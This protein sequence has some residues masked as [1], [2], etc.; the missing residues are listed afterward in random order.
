M[1]AQVASIREGLSFRQIVAFDVLRW[2]LRLGFAVAPRDIA[3]EQL[4]R[5]KRV[6]Q[7]AVPSYLCEDVGL[8]REEAS[9]PI[10]PAAWP[11]L[12]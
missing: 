9:R 10:G 11:L 7:P 6:R 3:R 1:N 12:R 5:R 8:P 2:N 4:R